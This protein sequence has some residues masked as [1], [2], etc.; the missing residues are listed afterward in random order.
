MAMMSAIPLAGGFLAGLIP[1]WF[2][3]V[4][5]AL[6]LATV[7]AAGGRLGAGHVQGKWDV[8]KAERVKLARQQSE[9][10]AQE[11]QTIYAQKQERL[12]R[13][14]ATAAVE[15]DRVRSQLDA[16]SAAASSAE[17]TAGANAER[18]RVLGGLLSESLGL[19]EEGRRRVEALDARVSGLQ[20]FTAGVCVR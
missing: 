20:A 5:Y 15:L 8:E 13:S 9:S 19:S 7:F 2:R 16:I 11:V 10:V 17:T 4:V 6:I 3:W 18:V 12:A 1:P 14:N